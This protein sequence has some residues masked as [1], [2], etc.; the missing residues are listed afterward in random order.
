MTASAAEI[1]A[2]TVQDNQLAKLFGYPT[3]GAGGSP[4]GINIGIYSEG[5]TYVTRALAVRSSSVVTPEYPTS[6]YIENIGVRPNL[7]NDLETTDN[8][9]DNGA[10]FQKAF[11]KAASDLAQGR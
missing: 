9:L 11:I 10:I 2:S 6:P 1:F 8:L 4:E 3:M 7:L 5:Y